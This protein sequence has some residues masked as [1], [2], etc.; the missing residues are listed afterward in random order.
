MLMQTIT[1]ALC[2]IDSQIES[3]ILL[4]ADTGVN[5]RAHAYEKGRVIRDDFVRSWSS[6][7]HIRGAFVFQCTP[8]ETAYITRPRDAFPVYATMA[9]VLQ[10]PCH[11]FIDA[12]ACVGGDTLAAMNQFRNAE[13]YSIQISADK[14]GER[15][16]SERYGRLCENIN[17]FKTIIPTRH[18]LVQPVGTDIG[19]FIQTYRPEKEMS[20]LFLD[21]PWAL[22]ANPLEQSSIG[23]MYT[24]LN[25]N[26]WVHLIH[27][28]IFP[29]LI[30]LKLP[31][32]TDVG[33]WPILRNY[34]NLQTTLTPRHKFCIHIFRRNF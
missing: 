29:V 14:G 8:D 25:E 21:P 33:E 22:G 12:F 13:I 9:A 4:Q 2:R 7:L 27:G 17:T 5:A 1:K 10:R 24:F 3:I 16:N 28:G 23:D 34:Y 31:M 20:V 30:V 6:K 11:T 26:V 32:D 19:S 15:T 18:A